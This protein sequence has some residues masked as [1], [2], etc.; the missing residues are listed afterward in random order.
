MT[1]GG[2]AYQM[3][4]RVTHCTFVENISNSGNGG[5]SASSALYAAGGTVSHCTITNN[6]GKNPG[7]YAGGGG[8]LYVGRNAVV[9][10]CLVAGNHSPSSVGGVTASGGFVV[11][12]TIAGNSSK[13][14]PAGLYTT[15]K[16]N[17]TPPHLQNCIIQDNVLAADGSASEWATSA[18]DGN[19]TAPTFSRCLSPVALL[20][21]DNV[22][23]TAIF[24]NSRYLPY[25]RS[26]GV[27][28]GSVTG[29]EDILKGTD[30]LG[31][32]RIVG[33]AI[34]IGA[35]EAG[36]QTLVIELR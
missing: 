16:A 34:D 24:R 22:L 27:N 18:A 14:A 36:P 21:A 23:G 19:S 17:I 12:C 10:N 6:I 8:A 2:G 25:Q 5:A 3:A 35:V 28:A 26:P 33:R 15:L 4:G 11:N 1:Y 29:F 20:G 32:P 13:S 9:D 30:L 31:R 7:G